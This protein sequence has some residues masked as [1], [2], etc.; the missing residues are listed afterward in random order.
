MHYI[1]I[2]CLMATVALVSC[3]AQSTTMHFEEVRLEKATR[4]FSSIITVTQVSWSRQ[5]TSPSGSTSSQGTLSED[6][7]QKVTSL[8]GSISLETMD[9][10]ESPSSGRHSDRSLSASLIITT[11]DGV[12]ESQSFDSGAPPGALSD[13]V[14]WLE[15]LGI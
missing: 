9:T 12:Y 2:T 8:I 5:E 11:S 14:S 1:L 3:K 7:K 15:A 10:L 4:G 6:E 13:L